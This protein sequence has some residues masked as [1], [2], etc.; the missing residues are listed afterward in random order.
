MSN[1]V[2]IGGPRNSGKSTLAASLYTQLTAMG[3]DIGLHEI[4]TFSD[5]LPCILGIKPWEQ[6]KKRRAGDWTDPL[7][8]VRLKEFATDQRALVLGDLP[9]VIDG[10]LE[11]L[12]KPATH[13]V[14]V[15]K[16]WVTLLEWQ[17]FF[18]NRKIPV[19]LQVVSHLGQ[20][21]LIPSSLDVV[22]VQDLNRQIHFDGE[23]SHVTKRILQCFK[24]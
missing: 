5:T 15:A 23:V 16:D 14:I 3:L 8:D 11:K 13:A 7:I 22:Y 21:P 17:E 6:R 2:V 19:V 9:G 20:P 24:L 10:L 1:H 12:V 18:T 4:D